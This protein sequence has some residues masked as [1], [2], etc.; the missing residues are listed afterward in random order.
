MNKKQ[1]QLMKKTINSYLLPFGG[2]FEFMTTADDMYNKCVGYF[3]PETSR[4]IIKQSECDSDT[5]SHEMA[6]LSQFNKW[7]KTQCESTHYSKRDLD[8]YYDFTRLAKK[9]K[10]MLKET[11][12]N[13]IWNSIFN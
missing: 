8:L 6:H 13:Q 11:G 4:I 10:I 12:F 9:Y 1:K 2:S 7:G 3:D 5:V